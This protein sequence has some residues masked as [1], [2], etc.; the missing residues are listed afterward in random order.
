MLELPYAHKILIT[1]RASSHG[2]AVAVAAHDAAKVALAC[3]VC[4]V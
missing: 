4:K 3:M 1:A 2:R